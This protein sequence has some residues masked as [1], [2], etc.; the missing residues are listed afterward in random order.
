MAS[1]VSSAPPSATKPSAGFATAHVQ[2]EVCLW[3]PTRRKDYCRT[4]TLA[5]GIPPKT[6]FDS[7]ASCETRKMQLAAE[8]LAEAKETLGFTTGWAGNGYWI[9]K[10]KCVTNTIRFEN[11]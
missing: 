11:D 3:S 4:V 7:A 9:G 1:S 8:W 5:P 6:G 2:A 10:P